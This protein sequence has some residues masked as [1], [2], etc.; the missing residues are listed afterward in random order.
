MKKKKI[1]KPTQGVHIIQ[2]R[3]A[4]RGLLVNHLIKE[5]WAYGGY[6]YLDAS[7]SKHPKLVEVN[8]VSVGRKINLG[9]W[10]K[11]TGA[12]VG[13]KQCILCYG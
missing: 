4:N 6:G 13:V 3:H 2:Y 11:L 10:F 5:P 12:V 7:L 1:L 9:S 8:F